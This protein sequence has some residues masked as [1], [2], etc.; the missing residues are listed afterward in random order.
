M[1]LLS[2]LKRKRTTHPDSL[3]LY[4]KCKEFYNEVDVP[5]TVAYFD[6]NRRGRTKS[7]V[8]AGFSTTQ[9]AEKKARESEVSIVSSPLFDGKYY[10]RLN[11][12]NK[13]E[14][15][16]NIGSGSIEILNGNI[17]IDMKNSYLSTG[18]N[19]YYDTFTGSI[20]SNG[21]IIGNI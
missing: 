9:L 3:N 13:D 18:S 2:K 19:K 16:Q 7:E 17:T 14:G 8:L 15:A 4:K 6:E 10:F 11:R 12:Y 20:D 1:A 21:D 5:S